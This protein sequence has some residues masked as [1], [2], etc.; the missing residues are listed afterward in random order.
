MRICLY[1]D[2]ALPKMGGQEMVVDAL[3]RQFL[4]LG[5]EP[6]VLAPQPRLPLRA[7][8]AQLPYTVI[9]HPRFISTRFLVKWYRWFLCRWHHRLRF[10]VLHCHGI[11]PPAYLASLSRAALG[12][13]VVV[14]SHGGDVNPNNVRLAKPVLRERHV[15]GLGWADALVA[16]SRYTRA[17]FER[18][19]PDAANIVDIPNGVDLAPFAR[20]APVP[21]DLDP[22]IRPGEYLLFLGRLRHRKGVDVLLDSLARVPGAGSVQLVVA[23]DGEIRAALETLCRQLGLVD[24]VRFVGQISGPEKVYLLQNAR[25]TVVPSRDWEAFA[26]VTLESYAAGRPVIASDLP[27][28]A[29][30]V[31]PGR[32]GFI[33]PPEAPD[34]LAERMRQALAQPERMQQMGKAARQFV[35]MYAWQAVA[36][37]HV[38]LYEDL[39]GSRNYQLLAA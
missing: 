33:V 34:L 6:I 32:T 37:R 38:N 15:Q 23:G 2:T 20:P 27:G 36:A 17:G 19:C 7:R 5:H 12:I 8:D 35:R 29:D 3:A 26:L 21:D 25:A 14:T 28:L 10:D 13:P 9:R 39:R 18:L 16:N 22:A 24:R 30:N 4:A 1:T 31:Q 11:Y